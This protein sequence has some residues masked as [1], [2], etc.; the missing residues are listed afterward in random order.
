[1]SKIKTFTERGIIILIEEVT[2]NRLPEIH[3]GTGQG[4]G[5]VENLD[6]RDHWF[7]WHRE[8]CDPTGSVD[9]CSRG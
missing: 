3:R 1:M 7:G 5:A 6:R 9:L 8:F 2:C 4:V